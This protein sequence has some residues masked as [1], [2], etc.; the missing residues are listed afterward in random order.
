MEKF[1]VFRLGDEDFGVGIGRVVEILRSQKVYSI[2][3]LPEFLSGVINVR[4]EVIPLLDLRLRFG[5]HIPAKKSRI[6]TVRYENG[7]IGLLVD[8]IEEIISLA[9][10]DII[11]SPSI[12]KGLKTE[13][14]T[15]L[16][17]KEDK[18]IILLNIDRLLTS[19][20]KIMLSDSSD[21]FSAANRKESTMLIEEKDAGN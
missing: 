10:E 21:P 12:F 11:P 15:G 20:E 6:I 3:E 7:K 19:E 16:G 14:L 1:A 8:E 13:Y 18:I 4:G 2:P 9:P 5:V 17:K